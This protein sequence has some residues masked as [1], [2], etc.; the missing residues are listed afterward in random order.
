MLR[1][2][3]SFENLCL[4]RPR[5]TAHPIVIPPNKQGGVIHASIKAR[6]NTF[7]VAILPFSIRRVL[8]SVRISALKLAQFLD[9]HIR[10][11]FEHMILEWLPAAL[12]RQ[13]LRNLPPRHG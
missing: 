13:P 3:P 6:Q 10:K 7:I 12:L 4:D 8:E 1:K 11:G 2:I 9:V 5:L